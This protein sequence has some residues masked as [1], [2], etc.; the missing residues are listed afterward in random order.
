MADGREELVLEAVA[1]GQLAVE[2]GQL[3]AGRLEDRRALIAQR[4]D[5]VGQGEGKQRHFDRRADLAG[6]HG[7]EAVR[8]V[9]QH[10]QGV[11]LPADEQRTPGDDE[12]ACHAHAA[13]P[14]GDARGEYHEREQQG[15][16]CGRAQRQAVVDPHRQRHDHRRHGHHQDQQA[17]DPRAVPIGLQ[18]AAGE[19]AAE[20]ARGADQQGCG[21]V[22]PVRVVGPEVLYAGA[23]D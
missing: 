14:G 15:Q 9:A 16:Q 1:F 18:E 19:L 2:R 12:I 13:D 22:R 6:V 3:G 11:D 21:E 17:I 20:Q 23:V 5:T 7:E 4:I 10:H 8:Q